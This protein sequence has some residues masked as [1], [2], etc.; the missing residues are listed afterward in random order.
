DHPAAQ[1]M[2]QE[3][4]V[5]GLL[6]Q[7]GSAG[8]DAAGEV[9]AKDCV[10]GSPRSDDAIA[11]SFDIQAGDERV[12]LGQPEYVAIRIDPPHKW[13]RHLDFKRDSH[14]GLLTDYRKP[15][16]PAQ[17]GLTVVQFKCLRN[18]DRSGVATQDDDAVL[19]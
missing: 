7:G 15:D 17:N 14:A 12:G 13:P 4:P 6:L 18:F 8:A 5:A 19:T 9:I 10:V 2:I 11:A 1:R 16:S 3:D